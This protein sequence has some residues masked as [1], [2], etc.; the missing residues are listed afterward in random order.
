MDHTE[1]NHKLSVDKLCR[2]CGGFS[3]STKQKKL[4]EKPTPIEK[5]RGDLTLIGFH[6]NKDIDGVH[7]KFA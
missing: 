2:L 1:E 7:S 6:F 5:L 4:Y 3:V